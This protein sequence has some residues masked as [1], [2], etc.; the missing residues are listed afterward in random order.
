MENEIENAR[1]G[2]SAYKN[3]LAG[4]SFLIDSSY[5]DYPSILTSLKNIRSQH[6]PDVNKIRSLLFNSWNSEALLNLPKF[7]DEEFVKFSNHWSPVQSYYAIYLALRGLIIARGIGAKGDHS[8]TLQVCVSNFIIGQKLFPKPWNILCS[9]RGDFKNLPTDFQH[10]DLN[11][12]ENPY[13]FRNDENKLINNFRMFLKTTRERVID[14]KADDWKIK[15]PTRRGAR[16]K[17]PKGK[18][19]ELDANTRDLSFLDCF[20]RLRTRSNYRDV[21]IFILGSNTYDSRK[22]LDSL[23]NITDKTLFVL[24]SYIIQSVGVGQLQEWIGQYKNA[25]Q[26]DFVQKDLAG[27][28]R[29][30]NFFEN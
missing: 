4:L 30:K 11:I 8:T 26:I 24:E 23:C 15:N 25:T 6:G 5:Q 17:L 14:E 22:Y 2:F 12:Q 13:H 21:D 3:Y 29:R 19:V 16:M 27:I 20:Y 28:T 18:R 1:Y 7:L 9:C 10:C